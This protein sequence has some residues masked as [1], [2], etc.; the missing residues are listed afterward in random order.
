MAPRT[1]V[2]G[3]VAGVAITV[4]AAA[5]AFA[6]LPQQS[7]NVDLQTGA[8]QHRFDGAAA[9]QVFGEHT[10]AAGDVNGDGFD[11]IVVSTGGDGA[12][13]VFGRAAKGN[14]KMSDASYGG[15]KVT[16]GNF[17][18]GTFAAAAGDQNGDD[19]D[20]ILVGTP[21]ADSAFVIYGKKDEGNVNLAS[22]GSGGYILQGGAG[23]A[24]G[25]WVSTS[26]DMNGDGKRELVIGAPGADNNGR[27]DSGSTYVV[28]GRAGTSTVDLTALGTGGWRIDGAV[29]N[30]A[31]GDQVAGGPDVNG[32]G[33]PDVAV[34]DSLAS[35]S[36][37]SAGAVYVVFGKAT[38]ANVDLNALGNGGFRI[39]GQA[40]S[41]QMPRSLAISPD[42][43]GDGRAEVVSGASFADNPDP[44]TITSSGSVYVV[45]GKTSTSSVA[46]ATLGSGGFRVDGQGSGQEFGREMGRGGD[47]NGDGLPDIVAGA[48]FADNNGRA[49]SGSV[50]VIFGRSATSTINTNTLGSQGF[51][52]DG[53]LPGDSLGRGA[54][55]AGD[56]NGDGRDDVVG[57][58]EFA[59]N[60]G[61]SSGSAY[62]VLGFGTPVV[63]Y[64][65]SATGTVG[66][67]LTPITPSGVKRTGDVSFGIAPALPAGLAID[68]VSGVISGTPTASAE[69][70]TYTV[71]MS[72]L[73]GTATAPISLKVDGTG[74]GGS[75]TTTTPTTTTTT[76][77]TTT[78]PTPTPQLKPGACANV[79]A[80]T[81]AA[82]TLTGT[83]AGDLIRAGGGNDKISGLAG[84]DCLF[85]QAGND[86]LDGGA[87]TDK[88]DGG[89]GNDTLIGGKGKDAFTAGAGNDTI[90]SKDGTVETVNC[91]KGKDKVKAD[92]KDKLK[93]CE[94]RT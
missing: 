59:D 8:F 45:F 24:G 48:L 54:G 22:L 55:G 91:G 21:A 25:R 89:A 11:D 36:F 63:S 82:E 49:D 50:Y 26:P 65:A 9:G 68:H 73:A 35:F 52:I 30:H 15:F 5:T 64:P 47:V 81:S 70:A 37:A 86:R 46:L 53:A 71:V 40:D 12:Y 10:V 1:R 43:N 83:T 80:G 17:G 27:N 87:G 38:P 88:L 92:K 28:Y 56:F 72:D 58:A 94:K 69:A 4:I 93:G 13:V 34:G 7:G 16:G 66:Q 74:G 44:N 79:K 78:T 67:A 29:T 75:G 76:T 61:N 19:L 62:V 14:A 2:R 33:I 60:N 41:D 57:G 20:D 42:M 77:P 23:Q 31:I 39:D 51:R 3:F 32:D 90:N 6:A 84:A 85:G 18:A